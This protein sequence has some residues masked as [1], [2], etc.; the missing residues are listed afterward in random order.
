MSV[1][2]NALA[3]GIC[4]CLTKCFSYRKLWV[5]YHMLQQQECVSAYEILLQQG[6]VSVSRNALTGI[7][8]C[9]VKCFSNR[10]LWESYKIL[11]SYFVFV[12]TKCFSNWNLWVCREMIVHTVSSSVCQMSSLSSFLSLLFVTWK[13]GLH[14]E[15]HRSV[16]VVFL[17]VCLFIIY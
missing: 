9:L 4:E 2:R 17:F 8:E 13:K 15:L 3:T 10:N 12:F 16:V 5:S 7:C 11:S 1:L 6:F 14:S